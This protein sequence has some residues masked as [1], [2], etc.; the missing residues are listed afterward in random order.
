M[1]GTLEALYYDKVLCRSQLLFTW[2]FWATKDFSLVSQSLAQFLAHSRHL[3]LIDRK[4][5]GK[6]ASKSRLYSL[7]QWPSNYLSEAYRQESEP[8]GWF[9]DF[10]I[11]AQAAASTPLTTTTWEAIIG[12]KNTLPQ[13][14]SSLPAVTYAC[15]FAPCWLHQGWLHS[16]SEEEKELV[17]RAEQTG[18]LSCIKSLA[19]AREHRLYGGCSGE[20]CGFS[21]NI[22]LPREKARERG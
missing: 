16:N 14:C 8:I 4:K 21:R 18:S 13:T 11:E 10:I 19:E 12:A 7:K 1:C 3:I 2:K 15:A 22:M 5:K 20:L 6:I 9:L 17:T